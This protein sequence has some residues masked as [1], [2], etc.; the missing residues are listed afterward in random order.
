MPPVFCATPV[1][2]AYLRHAPLTRRADGVM[3]E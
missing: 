3:M 2:E 1:V